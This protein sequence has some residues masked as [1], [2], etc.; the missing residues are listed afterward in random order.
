MRI[1]AVFKAVGAVTLALGA[2]ILLCAVVSVLYREN[3]LPLA[4]GGASAC[5]FGAA[6]V[7]ALRDQ[8]M[9]A[10]GIREGCAIVTFSWIFGCLFG[11]LPFYMMGRLVDPRLSITFAQSYFE[12]MSGLT[13]TGSSIFSDVEIIP[14]G[15]L[16]WRSLSHWFG[17]MGI[18]VFAVAIVPRLG[19]GG[20]QAFRMESPGPVKTDKLVPR[21]SS[22]AKILYTVY[23][24]VTIVQVI[25]ML[26]A[27]VDLFNALVYTFGTVGTGGFGV[28]NTSVAGLN[29]HAAEYVIAF[30]MWLAGVNFA[31][32]YLAV[33]KRKLIEALRD[34]EF[35]VYTGL[36]LLFIAL[37]T[38]SLAGWNGLA[39]SDAFRLAAFQVPTILT[40]TGYATTDYSLWP[41]FPLA[42]LVIPMFIGGS[43]GSTGGGLKVLRHMINV[44]H[45]GQ[46]LLRLTRPNLKSLVKIGGRPIQPSIVTSVLSL[47][48]LWMLC[49]LLGTLVMAFYGFDLVTAFTAAVA[50]LGNI[51]PGLGV[52]GPAGNFSTVPTVPLWMLTFLMLIGR[53]EIFTVLA[54]FAPSVWRKH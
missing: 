2:S 34:E 43:V 37:I 54:L 9:A 12:I 45:I 28:H 10:V 33:W 29:N 49:I 4:I 22:S 39:L 23:L 7:L 52:V 8:D 46:E 36:T 6:C 27:G 5:L 51:G 21:I 50:C 3:P 18:V 38:V 16:F 40:T 42:I 1:A 44:K 31:L 20:M 48:V 11:A 13:T 26:L 41:V 32:T 24:G 14:K 25:A 17:G 15:I 53:L 35:R 19:L 30:F 47:T